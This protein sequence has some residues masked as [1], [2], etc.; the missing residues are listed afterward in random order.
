LP[1]RFFEFV[2]SVAQGIG[3][4]IVA[5]VQFIAPGARISAE[6][7]VAVGW[8]ALLTVALGLT[9][10]ARKIVWVLVAIGWALVLVRLVM[11]VVRA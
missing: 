8:L 9:E 4:A 2:D 3:R 1:S 6:L 5:G 11:A 10:A 7:V